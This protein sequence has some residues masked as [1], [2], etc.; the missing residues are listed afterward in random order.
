[1]EKTKE[2]LMW[3]RKW[4]F[5]MAGLFIVLSAV[6]WAVA[7]VALGTNVG[8]SIAMAFPVAGLLYI[9][10]ASNRDLKGLEDAS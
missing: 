6:M 1:M 10:Y 8:H 2:D 3:V 5:S 4:A 7:P 9:G